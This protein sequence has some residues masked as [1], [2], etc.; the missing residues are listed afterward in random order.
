M[1]SI[2]RFSFDSLRKLIDLLLLIVGGLFFELRLLVKI[3]SDFP[4]DPVDSGIRVER[5]PTSHIE[6]LKLTGDP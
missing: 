5:F 4:T 6:L 2:A 3:S 1:I